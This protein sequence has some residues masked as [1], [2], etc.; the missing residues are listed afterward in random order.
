MKDSVD[1]FWACRRT[2]CFQ[3]GLRVEQR[4]IE[5]VFTNP[6]S[7]KAQGSINGRFG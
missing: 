3:L 2:V 5:K 4:Q 7:P 1:G 6:L